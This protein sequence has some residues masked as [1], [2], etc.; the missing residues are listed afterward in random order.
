[1]TTTAVR[2]VGRSD[3]P[4]QP[5]RKVRVAQVVTKL[6]AGAGGITLRGASALDPE[7]Y[8][9]AIFAAE[10]G[11]LS[12]AAEDGGIEVIALRHMAGGRGIYPW[13]DARAYRELRAHLAGGEFDIVHT[14]SAKAG[15]LGRLA[16][17]SI[18]TRAVIHSFHGFPFHSFQPL[19]V[20][21]AL[22]AIERR[23]ART[24]DYFL[25][26]GTVTAAE[27]VRLDLAPPD[28]IRAITSPIDA[29]VPF[30]TRLRRTEARRALGIPEQAQVIGTVARLDAQK[31]PLDMVR[32]FARLAR[33]DAHMVWLG[34]GGLRRQTERLVERQGLGDRFHLLGSRSDAP[35][36]LPA[37]D[38]FV[39]PSLYEGLPCAVVEAMRCGIPVVATAVNSVPEI[40]LSGK[41]GLL[42]KPGDPESLARAL[43]YLLDHPDEAGTMAVRARAHVGERFTAAVLGGDLM[44]VYDLVLRLTPGTSDQGRD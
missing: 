18:G 41:T 34:D 30:L 29:D 13:G 33:P 28:R 24:T 15:A 17:R 26:D 10:A 20:R 6:A 44:E 39:M 4:I 1:V 37:F 16:A 12:E 32:A 27:A 5:V 21:S 8:E 23:L 40:V 19:P 25:A 38:V 36:L 35:T 31:A 7:R 3:R 2:S 14:H 22:L 11:P 9:T 42:A 43:A